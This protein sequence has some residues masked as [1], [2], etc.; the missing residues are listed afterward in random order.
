MSK[1]ILVI[2][3]ICTDKFIYGKC[4][5]LNPEA[6]TPVFIPEKTEINLGMAGNTYLNLNHLGLSVDIID[7]ANQG[8]EKMRFV[9]IDSNYILLRVDS[10]EDFIE[11]FTFNEFYSKFDVSK[12]DAVVIS[13]Y[14]K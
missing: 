9:D 2:G 12:F 1:K 5:R 3:E 6:P 7:K 4:N 10:G 14:S 13:D 11:E 8:I